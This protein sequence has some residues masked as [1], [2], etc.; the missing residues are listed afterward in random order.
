MMSPKKRILSELRSTLD[1]SPDAPH[2]RPPSLP[3]YAEQPER[4]QSAVNE[5]LR[6]RLVEGRKDAAG[7]MTIALNVHRRGDVERLLRPVWTHPAV[8]ATAVGALLVMA[9]GLAV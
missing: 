9:I 1:R 5:L 7:H 2:V 6:Q 4:Y 3:G 8:W